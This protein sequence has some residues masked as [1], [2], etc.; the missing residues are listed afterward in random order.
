[1]WANEHVSFYSAN[2]VFD[3]IVYNLAVRNV[4]T[5]IR[6]ESFHIDFD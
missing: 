3:Q 2:E 4:L 5:V 1:M 6:G